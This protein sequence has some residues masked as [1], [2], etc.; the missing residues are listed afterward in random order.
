MIRFAGTVHFRDGREERFEAG[1]A[2]QAD[3]EEYAA[4]HDLPT[5]PTP[6]TVTRFPVKRWQMYLAYA[7]LGVPEGFDV[8]RKTV[9]D[10]DLDD[11]EAELVPPTLPEAFSAR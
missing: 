1:G 6:E 11:D 7:A 2:I 4:R 8:W 9:S 10:V 3:W 5:I